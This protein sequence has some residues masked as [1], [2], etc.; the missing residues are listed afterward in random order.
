MAPLGTS[1]YLAHTAADGKIFHLRHLHS[2]FPTMR[3]PDQ[4]KPNSKMDQ[5][6]TT[7]D[8]DNIDLRI[9]RLLVILQ[10]TRSLA[11]TAAALGLSVSQASRLLAQARATFGNELFTRHGPEM[12]PTPDLTAI[13][14]R[15]HDLFRSLSALFSNESERKRS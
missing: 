10:D 15:L 5:P 1:R 9:L 6:M 7:P 4:P 13:L 14:P 3:D 2:A 11:R 12:I 8:Y